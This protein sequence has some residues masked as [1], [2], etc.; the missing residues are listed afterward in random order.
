MSR[1]YI[2]VLPDLYRR[3]GLGLL[4]EHPA[5]PP[6]AFAAYLGVLCL[7][8]E[9]T[10]RGY[11]ASRKVLAALLEGANGAGDVYA[12]E[13]DYLIQ[14]GDLTEQPDGSLYVDGWFELQEGDW[15]VNER[16]RRYR[17]R[18]N[19]KP[20]KP[21]I[22]A[23][24]DPAVAYMQ[25]IGHFPRGKAVEWIDDLIAKFGADATRR[26]ICAAAEGGSEGLLGRASDALRLEARLAEQ[27]ERREEEQKV[28]AGHASRNRTTLLTSRHNGGAHVGAPDPACPYCVPMGVVA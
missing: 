23:D 13:V 15:T 5:Y 9:Q 28:A 1:S 10:P 24:A 3:K 7:A 2:K 21:D 16:M 4:G 27:K 20:S 18:K 22:D 17:D 11:F 12:A 26:A 6:T 14:E 25:I 19:P 8:E